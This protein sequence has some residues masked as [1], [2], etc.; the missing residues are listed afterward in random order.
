MNGIHGNVSDAK[1]FIEI[2][3]RGNVTAAI[4]DAH[5]DLERSALAD[6]GDVDVLVENLDV[7]I[8]F[9]VRGSIAAGLCT[10]EVDQLR[11]FAVELQRNLFKVQDDIRGVFDD[12]GNRGKLVQD[13]LD[14]YSCN[15]GTLDR[16]QKHAAKSVADR[17]AEAAL[18][19]LCGEGRIAIV[20][21]ADNQSLGFLETFPKHFGISR[22]LLFRIQFDDHSFLDGQVDVFPLR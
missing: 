2:A 18:E 8:V 20:G 17:G 21:V 3:I 19:R 5:L 12:S 7:G 15:G 16:G 22:K 6:R 14:V 1:L 11:A 9:D 13:A 4:F 10:L